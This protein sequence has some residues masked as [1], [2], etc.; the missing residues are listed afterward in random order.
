[1]QAIQTAT[2]TAADLLGLTGKIGVIKTGA[3]ADMIAFKLDPLKDITVLQNVNWVMK[4]G[5][6]YKN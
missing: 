2:T 3:F 4:D 6:V 5:K 1:M